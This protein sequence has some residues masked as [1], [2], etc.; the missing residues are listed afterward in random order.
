[1]SSRA[2]SAAPSARNGGPASGQAV[3]ARSAAN[4]Y[5]TSVRV[6]TLTYPRPAEPALP[7][8]LFQFEHDRRKRRFRITGPD[9]QTAEFQDK[10]MRFLVMARDPKTK[11]LHPV[12]VRGEP[13]YYY[14]SPEVA[15]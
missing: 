4:F 5:D 14:L 2:S 11:K 15:P 7:P 8:P 1:M 12:L 3:Q 9:G 10:A 6:T 13:L